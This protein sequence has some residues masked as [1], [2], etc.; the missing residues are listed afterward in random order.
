M[1]LRARPPIPTIDSR[2]WPLRRGGRARNLGVEIWDQFALEISDHVLE[3]QLAHLEAFQLELVVG[4]VVD[5]LRYLRI[6]VAM[7]DAQLDELAG[8]V[9]WIQRHD[10]G[11][12]S[13]VKGK[14]S[15]CV[16]RCAETVQYASAAHA[17]ST[18]ATKMSCPSLILPPS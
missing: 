10:A 18:A 13:R 9:G 5:E 14:F 1:R 11:L 12:R 15:A 17:I 6:E 2:C 16:R 8:D 4:R 7:L 3:A